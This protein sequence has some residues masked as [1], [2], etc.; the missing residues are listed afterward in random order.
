M[1]E[2]RIE[3]A[4]ALAAERQARAEALAARAAAREALERQR[5]AEEAL[6]IAEDALRR[7]QALFNDMLLGAC[8]E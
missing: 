6:L 7:T 5:D 8:D 2:E 1:S 3:L 4:A